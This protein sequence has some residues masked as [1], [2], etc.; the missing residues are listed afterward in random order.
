MCLRTGCPLRHRFVS[1]V[2]I[3]RKGEG[4]EGRRE[5]GEGMR[6]PRY[7]TQLILTSAWGLSTDRGTSGSS[8]R[9]TK[10]PVCKW[11]CF[12]RP[13]GDDSPLFAAA[14]M[15]CLRGCKS[16]RQPRCIHQCRI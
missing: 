12:P 8:G 9:R 16:P 6:I 3:G 2:V 10:G 5:E 1:S 7:S 14:D 15:S 11:L 4:E 13:V